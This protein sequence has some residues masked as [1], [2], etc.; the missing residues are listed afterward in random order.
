MG[1]NKFYSEFPS[2]LIVEANRIANTYGVGVLLAACYLVNY[3]DGQICD[4]RN[5]Q[6]NELL[7]CDV[8]H[9]KE[10]RRRV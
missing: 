4:P 8:I 2:D 5:N 7:Y 10:S 6:C 1:L 9:R 3:N